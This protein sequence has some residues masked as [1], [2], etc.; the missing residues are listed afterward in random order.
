MGEQMSGADNLY[1]DRSRQHLID[2]IQHLLIHSNAI[3]YLE[4]PSGSGR[5][6]LLQ[7]LKQLMLS[8]D[9][10]TGR[11]L[12]IVDDAD[13]LAEFELTPLV[14]SATNHC[15]L[16]AG[17]PGSCE[18][19]KH[20]GFF[21]AHSV[22]RLVIAP[23]TPSEA[24]G[25]INLHCAP[26]SART[27]ARLIDQC[28]LYPGEL[29]Q[30]TYDNELAQRNQSSRAWQ[31]GRYAV[32]AGL[33]IAVGLFGFQMDWFKPLI[34]RPTAAPTMASNTKGKI[35]RKPDTSPTASG[36]IIEALPVTADAPSP[37]ETA[38]EKKV[39]QDVSLDPV[40]EP[41]KLQQ[42]TAPIASPVE[43][44]VTPH[45]EHQ[46]LLRADPQHFTLQLM[47]ASDLENLD[48]LIRRFSL[49]KSAFRYTR[50]TNNQTLYCLVVGDYQTYEAAGEGIKNLP[51]ELQKMGPWRRR[52]SDIQDEI[53]TPAGID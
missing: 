43:P 49:A 15:L 8:T 12:T 9:T 10:P 40:V 3:V 7:H 46:Q 33:V 11:S 27:R 37:P 34:Q 44:S 18:T 22:E 35:I 48:R 4:G 16:M 32:A 39:N 41:E 50:T 31:T 21:G 24:D 29:L 19:I 47:L 23:F 51:P 45:L 52:F 53:S 30:A 1:L 20:G 5:S 25:F 26:V 6:R 13:Q 42:A 14:T 36:A 17:L 28:R 2:L 38:F